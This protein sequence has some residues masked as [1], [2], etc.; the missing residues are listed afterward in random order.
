MANDNRKKGC[1]NKACIMNSK[2]ELQKN[3][4]DYCPKCGTKLVYVCVKCFREIEDN[5][6][7]HRIC[8]LCEAKK[9]E[10]RQDAIDKAKK[11]VV[12]AGEV[13]V[14]V[15]LGVAGKVIKNEQKIAIDKGVKVVENAIKVVLKR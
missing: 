7:K 14:P 6:R 15:V 9:E 5:N 1:P 10:K 2:K 3:D 12:K 8:G 4:I 11:G 13:V